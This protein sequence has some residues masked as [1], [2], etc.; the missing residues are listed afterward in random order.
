MSLSKEELLEMIESKNEGVEFYFTTEGNAEKEAINS[1]HSIIGE[2][3]NVSASFVDLYEGEDME[4]PQVFHGDSV[5]I[6]EAERF[7]LEDALEGAPFDESEL[8]SNWYK[9]NK[10]DKYYTLEESEFNWAID[11]A[12]AYKT[13]EFY[14]ELDSIYYID[15]YDDIIFYAEKLIEKKSKLPTLEEKIQEI[16]DSRTYK[17]LSIL[18]GASEHTTKKWKTGERDWKSAQ[19]KFILNL[20]RNNVDLNFL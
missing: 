2:Y 1:E 4:Y 18:S 11:Y 14:G 5:Y 10:T 15:N 3:Y 6:V 13:F 9:E 16:I 19:T 8:N 20:I 7:Y 17:E 12:Q